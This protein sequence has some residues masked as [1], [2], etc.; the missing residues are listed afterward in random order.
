MIVQGMVDTGATSSLI[1]KSTITKLNLNDQI[2]RKVG[3][4]MLGDSQTRIKQYGWINLDVNIKG[5]KFGIKAIVVDHLTNELILGMDFM[6]KF[7]VNI[8][9]THQQLVLQHQQQQVHVEFGQ[10]NCVR[11]SRPYT[12]HPRCKLVVDA[13]V[14]GIMDAKDRYLKGLTW[15]QQ[16][17][18]RIR[19]CDGLVDIQ[20]GYVQVTI[21]NPTHCSVIMQEGM[22]I[23]EITALDPG[24]CCSVLEAINTTEDIDVD[25]NPKNN[26]MPMDKIVS[27]LT[28]HL[29]DKDEYYHQ[30]HDT[31]EKYKILFDVN[32]QR[33]IK[34]TIHHV[35]DTGNHVPIAS[36]PYFKTIE[37]RKAIQSEIDKMLRAGIIIPSTSDWSSPV[38]L[39][40]KPDGTFRFIIDYRKLNA[41]TKKDVFPQPS[42]EELVQRLG[43]HSWFTKIDMKAG[44]YQ[45]PIRNQDKDKTAFVTQDGLYQFEVLPMGLMNAPPTFQR[46]MHNIIG[47]NRWDYTAVYLDDIIIFSDSFDQHVKHLQEI[48]QILQDHNFTLNPKKCSIAK[49]SIE[50]LSHT[51]TKE[52][53]I[54]LQERIQAILDI[55]QPT[56]LAQANK[57]IGKIGWY[58]K[59]IPHFS[60]I[61]A[62][63]HRVTNKI[64]SKRKDFHWGE[65]QIQAANKLKQILTSQPLVLK[66]PHPN[67]QFILATDASDYAIGGTLKQII[68]GKTHYN[69]FLSRLLSDTEKRYSTIEREALA[70]FW[71]LNK[72]QQYLGGRNVLIITDHKPLQQFQI[73]QKIN[74]KRITQ[75]L[76]KNQELLPQIVEVQY[77]KGSHHGDADGMSRPDLP[78]SADVVNVMTRAMKK[79]Q[80]QSTI[81]KSN[82]ASCVPSNH[83]QLVISLPTFDF[84]LSRIGTEQ[85]RDLYFGNIWKQIEMGKGDDFNYV[86]ENQVLYKVI[87]SNT[88]GML[89]KLICVPKSMTHEVIQCY[90][91]H[92]TGAHFGTNRT[93][94]KIRQVCYWPQMRKDVNEY[95]RSCEKCAKFNIRRMKSP[96]HLHPIE[97]PQGPLELVSMDFWGPTPEYSRNGNKYVL[98]ITDYFTRYVVATA[99]PNNTAIAAAKCFTEE[100]SFKFGIPR[101]LITDQGTHF[102]N[103]LMKNLTALLGTNHI[104]TSA[105]HPQANGLTERFNSTFHTQLAKF[106]NS[107][108]QDWDEYLGAVTY[109]YNTGIQ[110]TTRYTPFQ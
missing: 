83:T 101:R 87:K 95:I 47:Y 10:T 103:E 63:I 51:I 92:P 109:G 48:F 78:G 81:P 34:A 82:T 20:Q 102:N 100:F 1:T 93:W 4:I 38:V 62:P 80:V 75:W 18:A 35:I 9:M 50:F 36:K 107:E 46:L 85:Q 105:Y 90:H 96:G 8:N 97:Y 45:I 13:T 104:Q 43:G 64:K 14:N 57:F 108:L 24:E 89:F 65:E 31:V 58:R 26:P 73:K 71:C 72:L 59:F 66:Y 30:I 15:E 55:P 76:I 37:Q 53:I 69:Y 44:Y 106:Q 3:D 77:R 91:D 74:S 32:Q 70:I 84:S 28:D 23:G 94:L 29:L 21:Y 11:L 2:F 68:N 22:V 12:I 16:H 86:L 27:I 99:L 41:I 7:R 39:L 60:Q 42:V 19:L 67:A 79:A 54:P 5:R 61:A 98:V 52:S 56:T 40:T 49:Q 6:R 25:Q 88:H 110:G 17:A 33:T